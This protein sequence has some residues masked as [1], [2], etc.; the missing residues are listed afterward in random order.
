MIILEYRKIQ[1]PENI[2]YNASKV[3]CVCVCAWKQDKCP[4]VEDAGESNGVPALGH[5]SC[6]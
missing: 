3:V 1:M 2:C 5:L 4:A 6:Q